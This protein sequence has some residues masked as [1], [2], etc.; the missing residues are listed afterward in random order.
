MPLFRDYDAIISPSSHDHIWNPSPSQRN[1]LE[2][3][4]NLVIVQCSLLAVP[5]NA[6]SMLQSKRIVI[7]WIM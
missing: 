3:W 4:N 7:V 1:S 2:G 6:K 5:P